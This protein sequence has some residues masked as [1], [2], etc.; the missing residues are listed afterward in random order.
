MYQSYTRSGYIG[1]IGCVHTRTADAS[2]VF[3]SA[4][5]AFA[6]A[7]RRDAALVNWRIFIFPSVRLETNGERWRKILIRL[8]RDSSLENEFLRDIGLF[9]NYLAFPHTNY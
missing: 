1:T 8:S 9:L 5:D 7:A 2:S 4:A 3:M 6:G